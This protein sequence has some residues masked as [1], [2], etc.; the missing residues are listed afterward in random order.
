MMSGIRGTNTKPE[1][2]VRS[3][4]HRHGFR[5]RLH[6]R[7]LPGRP[8]I[9]LPRYRAAIFVHGCFWH[10]HAC[11]LFRLPSTRPEFWSA[12]IERNRQ[13]DHSAMA[14]LLARGW[15]VATV[16]ECALKGRRSHEDAMV[17]EALAGW[18]RGD[19]GALE[20]TGRGDEGEA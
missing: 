20:L 15:R 17:L 4:L 10:G 16:W 3:L 7:D 1:K 13:N 9:V 14:A 2:H 8:D 19:S 12:K 6:A 11:H 18:L 5:F